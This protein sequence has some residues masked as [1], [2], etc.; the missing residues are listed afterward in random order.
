MMMMMMMM[1][2]KLNS[3]NN[4]LLTMKTLILILADGG[5]GDFARGRQGDSAWKVTCSPWAESSWWNIRHH[6]VAK[7]IELDVFKES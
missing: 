1:M 2:L 5:K 3:N 4:F 6:R 7:V